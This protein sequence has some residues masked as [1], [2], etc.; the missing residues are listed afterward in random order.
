H[1]R[2]PAEMEEIGRHFIRRARE[3]GVDEEVARTIF[4]YIQ[5]Y[6]SYGFCEAHAA[7]FGVTAYKTAYLLAHY[8]AEWY[9]AVLSLQ[10]MGYYPPNT[11]C[12]EAMRRGIRILPLDIN[13]SEAGF[14]ALPS[15][16]RIG[17]R[18]LKGL[19]EEAAVAIVRERERNGPFRDLV[20]FIFRMNRRS[21]VLDRDRI[22]DLI[23]AGAFDRLHP[24]R[25]ATLWALDQAL[26]TA[27]VAAARAAGTGMPGLA[28]GWSPPAVADFPE[29]EK[30][31]LEREL[32]GID[33]HRR[34]LMEMLRPVL[35]ARG[36][37]SAAEVKAMPAGEPVRV[38]GIPVRPHRPPTRSGRIVVFLSLEDETGLLDVTV[39]ERIYQRDGRWIF[40][41]PPVPLVVEGRAERRDGALAVVAE[42]VFPLAA[43]LSALPARPLAHAH[44]VDEEKV[45][46]VRYPVP[47]EP[48]PQPGASP[49]QGRPIV[50]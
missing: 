22:A 23:R 29:A 30:W 1:A 19:G 24:N 13:E 35:A 11:L 33:V 36:Y 7:A 2:S 21:A 25:R 28:V 26:A 37:R 39:F 38:A 32:L 41:D 6:A 42:R 47:A 45:G 44:A 17:L 46:V 49:R 18:A 12:V 31:A 10:P 15:A 20:D 8:P 4:S 50:S 48:P 14:T 40:T 5:G 43:V 27:R 34:H 16:I 3:Q 9:A